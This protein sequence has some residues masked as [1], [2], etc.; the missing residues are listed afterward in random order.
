[1]CIIIGF[2]FKPSIHSV[3]QSQ[4][5]GARKK[6]HVKNCYFAFSQKLIYKFAI[7]ISYFRNNIS[8]ATIRAAT[9]ICTVAKMRKKIDAVFTNPPSLYM[10]ECLY[11]LKNFYFEITKN[12]SIA[13]IRNSS[14]EKNSISK[15]RLTIAKIHNI[16]IAILRNTSTL[17]K[18]R[19]PSF[20][21]TSPYGLQYNALYLV[22]FV[23]IRY[24]LTM[25]KVELI[26]LLINT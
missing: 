4:F 3:F 7:V 20:S 15:I 10:Q 2:F 9:A 21:K 24:K 8:P 22:K 23:N 5:Y 25:T 13:I 19:K 12:L 26:S 18:I 16:A 1:M 6:T 11:Y 17:L 14:Y